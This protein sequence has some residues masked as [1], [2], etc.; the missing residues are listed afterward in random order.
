M[1]KRWLVA[2]W[3][4]MRD[5]PLRIAIAFAGL[6]I[7]V[8]SMAI[9]GPSLGAAWTEILTFLG[10]VA[11]LA[12]GRKQDALP[13]PE[14]DMVR[15]LRSDVRE[16]WYDEART[17][18][19]LDRRFIPIDITDD[20]FNSH[21]ERDQAS[22]STEDFESYAI[23]LWRAA[24]G[25]LIV[26]G[27]AGSG[28]SVLSIMLTL[29][30]LGKGTH[31]NLLED[32]A[33]AQLVP[34]PIS[35]SSW[36]PLQ[37]DF[38]DW[39]S[40]RIANSYASARRVRYQEST[41]SLAR[42]LLA[43][44]RYLLILDSLDEVAVTERADAIRQ[45]EE[46]FQ[47]G[48][49]V[50]ILTRM[51]SGLRAAFA[52]FSKMRI[53]PV[54][55]DVT[56]RYLEQLPAVDDVSLAQLIGNLRAGD[57]R[58]LRDL[59]SRPL[60]IDLVESAL[61]NR[62]ITAEHLADT[63]SEEGVSA[64]KNALIRWRLEFKL[65]SVTSGG[66]HK[67]RYL[68]Y[69]A[70]QMTQHE[71]NVLPWW[72]LADLMPAIALVTSAGL[73]AA[74]PSYLVGLRMPIGLTRGLAIGITIG[75]SYGI[76]RGR[77]VSWKDLRLLAI[78]LPVGVWIVGCLL[79]GWRLGVDDSVEI[80]TAV[81]LAIRYRD[82]LFGP[83]FGSRDP[84]RSPRGELANRSN[85][86][87]LATLRG[88][89]AGRPTANVWQFL[90][91]LVSIGIVSGASTSVI[92][93]IIGPKGQ[94]LDLSSVAIPVIFGIGVAASAARLLIVERERMQPSSVLLKLT[95]RVGGVIGAYRAGLLSAVAIGLCGGIV[96]ALRFGTGYG[97][98]LT[99]AFGCIIGIPVGLV[100][101]AIRYLAA[102]TIKPEAFIDGAG[103]RPSS[104][105]RNNRLGP[106]TLPTDRTVAIAS[107]IGI[108]AA[109]TATTAIL[110]GPWRA[111]VERIDVSS[112]P[113]LV[114]ADGILFGVTIGLIVACFGTAWPTYALARLWLGLL[115]C[116]PVR[117]VSFIDQ[118]YHAEILRREGS[119]VLFRHYDF[120]EYL[121][122]HGR[123]FI[124]RSEHLE[125]ERIPSWITGP[126]QVHGSP[127]G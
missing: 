47:P 28:K 67:A 32:A 41:S 109:A 55:P 82:A 42:A 2:T 118:L 38:D 13:V 44:G 102:P 20:S 120:Q 36:R 92:A 24:P 113:A 53:A 31:N 5:Q 6:T 17:R 86:P 26:S 23:S 61:K 123:E 78:S 110:T 103:S 99:V 91:V 84:G 27:D 87:L 70:Q 14:N 73:L 121:N 88:L 112:G 11:L 33:S 107:I 116:S 15:A 16:R 71:T 97:I 59:L 45:L 68:V 48:V 119:Y 65:K 94:A 56:A 8:V 9:G 75:I 39:L 62:Q 60:Y 43:T 105:A 96:G 25:R 69:F 52:G 72:R 58:S 1:N 34:L 108:G 21:A 37:E 35:I 66:Q 115:G 54:L 127:P 79:V 51:V 80:T 19:L 4:L 111:L 64:L 81:V 95:P 101:G 76:L 3:T 122:L 30:L 124:A 125:D 40:R 114:T 22:W 7:I 57:R 77:T 18:G 49:P 29:G 74:I 89:A 46:F 85:P 93:A 98:T 83:K 126:R 100:G 117:L 50:I 10:T 63:G 90:I 12:F 106:S 104:R